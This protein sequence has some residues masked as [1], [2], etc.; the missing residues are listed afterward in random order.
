LGV[1]GWLRD[2]RQA[3][4]GLTRRPAAPA[5]A[6][7]VL[8]LGV[9]AN[10]AIFS[11]VDAVL[12]RRLPVARPEQLVRLFS[13][14][15]PE[16]TDR[17]RISRPFFDDYRRAAS[18][19]A[20]LEMW[21][22]GLPVD[23]VVE[24]GAPERLSAAAASPGF[25]TALG[26]SA[27]HGRLL[28]ASGPRAGEATAVLSHRLW[29]RAFH[30]D[31]DAIGETLLVNRHPFVIAGV[32]PPE[33]EGIS[34][35]KRPDLWLPVAHIA[36]VMPAWSNQT[37]HRASTFFH[38]VGRL[39]PGIDRTAAQAELRVIASRLGAGLPGREGSER[40]DPDWREPW[41]WLDPADSAAG[42][43][44]RPLA[45]LLLG[46]A[47]LVLALAAAD[48]A[49]LMLARSERRRPEIALRIALGGSRWRVVRPLALEAL[50][51]SAA[52]GLTGLGVAEVVSRVFLAFFPDGVG[53]F[54]AAG[55]AL[56]PRVL[57]ITAVVS[58]V[59][60][61]ITGLGPALR[62][63]HIDPLASLRD[64]RP[65]DARWWF[66]TRG[67]LVVIQFAVATVLLVG[68][69]ALLRS[70]W[71]AARITPG[72]DPER[73]VVAELD[74]ARGGYDKARGIVF[75]LQLDDML[76]GAPGVS[77][78]AVSVGP[79]LHAGPRTT[80]ALDGA[81]TPVDFVMVTPSYFETL[82]I[83]LVQGRVVERRD[84]AGAPPVAVVNEAFVR[85][86]WPASG[87]TDDDRPAGTALGRRIAGFTPRG[88]DLELIGV[89]GDV[90]T[91]GL[92]EP[93]QPRLYV[94]L[95]QFYDAFPF[96]FGLTALLRSRDTPRTVVRALRESVAALDPLLPVLRPRPL[97]EVLAADF[98][99]QRLL[100][101][102]LGA[103]A[104]LAVVLAGTGLYGL[105]ALS[106]AARTREFGVRLALG[107]W[108]SQLRR[109]VLVQSVKLAG[110]GL[111]VGL[112]G[113]FTA[114]QSLRPFVFGVSA[115]DPWAIGASLIGLLVL[116]GIAADVP[117]R[118][119]ARVDP[120]HALRHH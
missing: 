57:A 48:V 39:A 88:A 13:A 17:G 92:R 113:S 108:P 60:A 44:S 3:F 43:A 11:L 59:A 31:P 80:V 72:I 66:S 82:R 55:G 120:A 8:G 41:P 79:P 101:S 78:A 18:C 96:Q 16:G 4:R 62:A 14:S 65:Q 25:F 37:Q 119:A 94:P 24:G 71:T 58:A 111:L 52:G 61:I 110:L 102:L 103:F 109:L 33:F 50:L 83:P 81:S 1:R 74:L 49:G 53:P 22:E 63:G 38:A 6:V 27:S 23:V 64:E 26:V 118:R 73:V 116:S 112:A 28:E 29:R 34:L 10:V 107:A 69:G 86:F 32:A 47:G 90:R 40:E 36:T 97:A 93:P 67:G 104:I 70:L 15:S 45:H 30:G 19:F 76:R 54:A 68:T 105:V 12:F 91:R 99:E 51:I 9:G 77:A 20:S 89:V 117:A 75:A 42:R 7:L 115:T 114:A 2:L 85:R 21:S 95:A 84:H 5:L 87:S 98:A 100:S 56:A 106:S 35:D 46:V